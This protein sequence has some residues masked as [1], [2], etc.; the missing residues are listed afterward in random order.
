MKKVRVMFKTSGVARFI[1]HLDL[2]RIFQHAIR[3]SDIPVWY[4]EGYNQHI[5]LTFTNPL[6]LG[7][8][9]EYGIMETKLTDD[10]FN[11]AAV[12]GRL[13]ECLP[14]CISAV[15]SYE[16]ERGFSEI[17]F[18]DYTIEATVSDNGSVE[19]AFHSGELYCVKKGKGGE[20]TLNL[21]G[22][23]KKMD[24]SFCGTRIYVSLRLPASQEFSVNPGQLFETVISA[25]NASAGDVL[26]TRTAL[27]DTY[28]KPFR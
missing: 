21:A 8:L 15:E 14:D 24:I 19:K 3:R 28:G 17:A 6:S 10:E 1:S 2:N 9:N 11:V 20:K 4:T 12:A 5:Y 25:A 23:I 16:S 26:I 22:Y 27:L 7:F 13:N 18:S